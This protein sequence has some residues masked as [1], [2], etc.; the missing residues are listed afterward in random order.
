MVLLVRFDSLEL[1]L[2]STSFSRYR[3]LRTRHIRERGS[4][5]IKKSASQK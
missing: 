1:V 5:S 3:F 4:S 2:T